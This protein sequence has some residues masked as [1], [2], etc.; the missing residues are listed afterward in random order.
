MG[1]KT[2][3]KTISPVQQ[4]KAE[5]KAAKKA[6]RIEKNRPKAMKL[7]AQIDAKIAQLEQKRDEQIAKIEE[8]LETAQGRKRRQLFHKIDLIKRD[9]KAACNKIRETKGVKVDKLLG[10]KSLAKDIKRHWQLYVF[11]LLPVIWAIIFKYV[12]MPGIIIAFKK[13]KFKTGI[14]GSQWVGFDNFI[15][16]FNDYQFT[17]VIRNTIVLS[18]Y[19]LFA[20][21]PIPVI[22]ALVLNSLRSEKF[23]KVTSTVAYM[24]HFISTVILV[25]MLVQMLN[26]RIGLYGTIYSYFHNGAYAADPLSNV[27]LFKHLYVWSGVWQTFGWNSIIYTAALSAVSPDLHEAAEIDGASRWQRVIHIDLPTILPTVVIMLIMRMGH[28][29]SLGYEKVYLMQNDLNLEASEIISTYVYK[30][31]LAAATPNYSYSTTISLFNSIINLILI[32][33]VNWISGKVS[34]TSLW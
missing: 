2:A 10:K 25:G 8:K 26:V 33:S 29:M 7:Q 20:S 14:F 11:L 21:F 9:C 3:E 23:K 15:R 27:K 16:F 5:I 31:G 6:A 1:N 4:T 12:P 30:V 24:P 13:Y 34:D 17:R 28:V 18:M 32:N 22:F 19:S